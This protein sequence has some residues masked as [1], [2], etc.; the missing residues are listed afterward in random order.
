MIAMSLPIYWGN[1][2]IQLDFDPAS[3]VNVMSFASFD[4]AVERVL[5]RRR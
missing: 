2:D 1:P 5:A 3:F 4:A